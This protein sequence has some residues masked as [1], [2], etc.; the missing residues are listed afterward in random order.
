MFFL[1]SSTRV[2]LFEKTRLTALAIAAAVV[3][4]GSLSGCTGTPGINVK[5]TVSISESPQLPSAPAISVIESIGV[6]DSPQTVR[7][8]EIRITEGIGVNDSPGFVASIELNIA[9]TV[10]VSDSTVLT[11]APVQ[12]PPPTSPAPV[13]VTVAVNSPKAGEVWRVATS[14]NIGWTTS[15]EGVSYV[16]IYYST[17]GGKSMIAVARKE[18]DDGVYTWKVPNTPSKTAM[19]RVLAF[20]VKGETIASG[21]SGLFTLSLQ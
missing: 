2:T 15:G 20:N 6:T 10:N 13:N 19:V 17:D 3:A 9:E 14:Q 8:A 21:D 1:R 16:D 7:Q 11:P 5:E 4:I 18:T 12:F